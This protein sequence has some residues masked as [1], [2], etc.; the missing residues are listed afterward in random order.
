[1]AVALADDVATALGAGYAQI[2]IP[3]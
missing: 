3:N 2:D 1:V